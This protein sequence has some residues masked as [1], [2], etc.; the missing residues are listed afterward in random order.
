VLSAVQ[1]GISS[2]SKCT[3]GTTVR[4]PLVHTLDAPSIIW[5]LTSDEN[6]HVPS[7]S[8][9]ASN[10]NAKSPSPSVVASP[11]WRIV[12]KPM[13]HGLLSSGSPIW[14]RCLPMTRSPDAPAP[15]RVIRP[16]TV[17][18]TVVEAAWGAAAVLERE[19]AMLHAPRRSV[20]A[21]TPGETNQARRVAAVG[22]AREDLPMPVEAAL[23]RLA[24][25]L[26]SRIDALVDDYVSRMRVEAPDFFAAGDPA[27]VQATRDSARANYSFAFQAL[28]GGRD[29]PVHLPP[30]AA[31]EARVAAET[32]VPLDSLLK[33][34]YVGHSVAWDHILEEVER[35][36]LDAATRTAILQMT[37]RYAFSYVERISVLV[38]SE[39]TAVRQAL[40]RSR[41][42]R[43]ARLVDDVLAALPAD[44]AALGYPLGSRH[45]AAIAWGHSPER[46]L[47]D[48]AAKL[49]GRSLAVSGPVDTVWAWVCAAPGGLDAQLR[50][51]RPSAGT[52]VA[53]GPP[54]MAPPASGGVT[55]RRTRPGP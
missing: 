33:S 44:E 34:Y 17:Q 54:V 7:R 47:A 27:L 55:G 45:V 37:S 14:R 30:A 18:W 21:A 20:P 6:E 41:E 31:Q 1:P 22:K 39:Y 35:L 12:G 36:D 11:T 3:S 9:S 25:A 51:Y 53:L 4:S 28:G 26:Q 16:L 24:E 23:R 42:R 2:R 29:V 52:R 46:A 32:G 13:T 48:L 49:G 40:I 5:T 15:H 50:G 38:T 43:R 8:E 10:A 19:V